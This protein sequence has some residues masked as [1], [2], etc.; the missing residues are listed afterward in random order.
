MR[1]GAAFFAL[2]REYTCSVGQRRLARPTCD[3]DCAAHMGF[4]KEQLGKFKRQ[5]DAAM[6][7]GIAWQAASMQCDPV[8]C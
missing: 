1:N 5:M 3:Y 6:A 7:F 8:P 4:A 2:W